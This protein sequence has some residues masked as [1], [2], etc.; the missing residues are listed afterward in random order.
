M[1]GGE[2]DFATRQLKEFVPTKSE[3]DHVRRIF[4]FWVYADIWFVGFVKNTKSSLDC[5]VVWSRLL[6]I[7]FWSFFVVN[8]FR[9]PTI[10][11]RKILT[12]CSRNLGHVCKM[13]L[14]Q[15][16]RVLWSW[17]I[18]GDKWLLVTDEPVEVQ[19]LENLA[20]ILEEYVEYASN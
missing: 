6:E 8:D 3:G 15:T 14:I 10:C 18:N 9:P 11:S 5:Y 16:Q 17:P 13:A 20:I 7:R 12:R 4:K 2:L 19:D 1:F